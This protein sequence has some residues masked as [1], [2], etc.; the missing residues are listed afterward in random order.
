MGTEQEEPARA[1]MLTIAAQ[2]FNA[3]EALLLPGPSRV[4]FASNEDATDAA[5]LEAAKRAAAAAAGPSG[6]GGGGAGLSGAV[7]V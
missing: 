6:V 7:N 4:Q 5:L 2:F 1:A 3:Y